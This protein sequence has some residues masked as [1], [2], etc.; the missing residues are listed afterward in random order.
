MKWGGATCGV[1]RSRCRQWRRRCGSAVISRP[2]PE[3]RDRTVLCDPHEW[4][5]Q[6]TV[7][8]GMP[9]D[10]TGVYRAGIGGLGLRCR[11]GWCFML[12]MSGVYRPWCR[13]RWRCQ[14]ERLRRGGPGCG[15]S[16]LRRS[17]GPT[18]HGASSGSVKS[19]DDSVVRPGSRCEAGQRDFVR[20]RQVTVQASGVISGITVVSPLELH[21]THSSQCCRSRKLKSLV[22]LRLPTGGKL[23]SKVLENFL[24]QDTQQSSPFAL[25]SGR[26]SNC[27]PVQQSNPAK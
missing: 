6:A 5:P 26:S 14:Q 11:T 13:Q 25:L 9:G 3:V 10:D 20:C 7:Q 4:C 2:K 15:V 23:Y 19:S 27:C 24:K 16:R 21:K 18:G 12:L 1:H 17:A 22:S 8:A